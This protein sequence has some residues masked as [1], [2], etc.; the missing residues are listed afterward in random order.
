[1]QDNKYVQNSYLEENY[2][3][4]AGSGL[5]LIQNI[6]KGVLM[7]KEVVGIMFRSVNSKQ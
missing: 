4:S 7:V 1:M 5:A 6:F 2:L 3:V